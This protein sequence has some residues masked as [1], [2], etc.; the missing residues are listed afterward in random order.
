MLSK[1]CLKIVKVI[2]KYALSCLTF[3]II[4]RVDVCEVVQAHTRRLPGQSDL[5]RLDQDVLLHNWHLV[6]GVLHRKSV[7]FT[8]ISWNFLLNLEVALNRE[9]FLQL[10]D[11]ALVHELTIFILVQVLVW[12]CEYTLVRAWRCF[13]VE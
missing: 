1:I 7:V 13:T 2:S 4:H 10:L 12:H 6:P 11:V 5:L 8:L 9:V 3:S